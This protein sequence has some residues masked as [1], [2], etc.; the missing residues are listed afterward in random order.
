VRRRAASAERRPANIRACFRLA[1]ASIARVD[2]RRAECR[3][4]LLGARV[5]F[6]ET[7]GE[8]GAAVASYRLAQLDGSHGER[9]ATRAWLLLRGIHDVERWVSLASPGP[10]DW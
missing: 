7:Q 8:A 2:G 1:H 6:E 4:L 5:D 9:A 10:V 3:A